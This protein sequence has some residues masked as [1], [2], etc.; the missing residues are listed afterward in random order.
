MSGR[1]R[2]KSS[3]RKNGEEDGSV[4]PELESIIHK[5]QQR[6]GGADE[7]IDDFF[8]TWGSPKEAFVRVKEASSPDFSLPFIGVFL[9]LTFVHE[10]A[11]IISGTIVFLWVLIQL[12]AYALEEDFQ[13]NIVWNLFGLLGNLIFYLFIGAIVASAKLYIDYR[14]AHLPVAI[15]KS[16]ET[17]LSKGNIDDPCTVAVLGQIRWHVIRWITVWPLSLAY[18]ISRDP[19]NIATDFIWTQSKRRYL[20]ILLLAVQHSS[21]ATATS[22]GH[23]GMSWWTPISW[24]LFIVLYLVIGH[25]WSHVK[26]FIDVWQAALP[27]SAQ[28][29]VD[30]AAQ[31]GEADKDQQVLALVIR[32]KKLVVSWNILWPFSIVYTLLRHPLRILADLVYSLSLKSYVWIMKRGMEW[33]E[34]H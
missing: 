9:L 18:T 22:G 27:K 31:A 33:R 8:A 32:L 5:D 21:D 26:L 15:L 1:A 28:D 23:G 6:Q 24:L 12:I 2:S 29:Q 25:L 14:Q 17:C 30:Q 16:I 3:N 13:A 19:L 11:P 4:I 7:R 20:G 10:E 34:R